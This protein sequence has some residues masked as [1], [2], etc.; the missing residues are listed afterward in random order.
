MGGDDR[1]GR[2]AW[3]GD[4]YGW[5]RTR[6]VGLAYKGQNTRMHQD[7]RSEPMITHAEE[8]L[9]VLNSNGVI[10]EICVSRGRYVLECNNVPGVPETFDAFKNWLALDVPLGN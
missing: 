10:G 8:T 1:D 6:G 4:D 7:S 9:M 3:K 5:G 2:T